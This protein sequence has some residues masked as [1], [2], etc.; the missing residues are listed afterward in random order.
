MILQ[1][2]LDLE[3]TEERSYIDDTIAAIATPYGEGGVGIIRISGSRS[4]EILGKIFR[5]GSGSCSGSDE[6]GKNHG[7]EDRKL[8][9]GHIV[10]E[11]GNIIDEVLAVVM[12]APRTYTGEEVAEIDCHGGMVPLRKTLELVIRMG[13]RTAERGEFTKRAFLNGRIDLSQAEAVMDIVRAKT[14]TTYSAAIGQLEGTVS[15]S[16]R[17]IRKKI[18]DILV[19]LTVNIDYP[20]EDIEIETYDK[21][22]SGLNDV[23]SDLE[24]LKETSRTGRIISEGL[25][26]AIIGKPNVGKSSLMNALLRESRAIVTDV[27]GTT[28]DTIEETLDVKGIPVILIDT[29]GIHE[30]DD[31]VENIGIERSKRS[32]ESADLVIFMLD[33]SSPLDDRDREIIERVDPSK[34]MIVLNK[35]DLGQKITRE[36]IESIFPDM[37]DRNIL[38]TSVK[39]DEGVDKIEDAVYDRVMSGKSV[40]ENS[41]IITNTR[42]IE[43]LDSSLSSIRDAEAAAEREEPF[44]IIEIDVNNAYEQLGEIIGEEVQDDILNEVFSRFCLGK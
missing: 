26:T 28:R 24:S 32:L 13:A 23:R 29:A 12:H 31:K 44:E 19:D 16:I 37:N 33:S 3:N 38:E 21:L 34:T 30:T 43:L 42:H 6:G 7:F 40:N 35:T 18:M 17:D 8:T 20:D 1:R 25:R 10:D 9:Y 41:V 4:E 39:K 14:D 2:D 27:P 5:H 15:D 36:E 22:R 11:D